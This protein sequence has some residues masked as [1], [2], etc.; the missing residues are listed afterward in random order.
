M[1]LWVTITIIVAGALLIPA[2]LTLGIRKAFP[3]REFILS[4]SGGSPA[5]R[6][7]TAIYGLMLAF[8]LAASL[9]SF[10]AAQNQTVTEADAVVAIGNLARSLPT[11]NGH[12]VQADLTCYAR[13]V[14]NV[15]FPAIAAGN[16]SQPDDDSALLRLYHSVSSLRLGTQN[17]V[18]TAQAVTTQLSALTDARDAR[19]RAARSSLPLLL[20]LVVAGGGAVVVLAVAAATYVDR[21]WPQF[22]LLVGVTAIILST[23]MLIV[24]LQQPFRSEGIH[25]DSSAMT[26]ALASVSRG[27]PAPAC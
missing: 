9:Q 19:I 27:I 11:A 17:E 12:Q 24:T 14:V 18:A 23:I 4:N 16:T 6:A 5:L 22:G 15:E 20:W 13:S 25:I 26:A 2:L 10:V 7:I 1:N 8:V 3:G 21:P